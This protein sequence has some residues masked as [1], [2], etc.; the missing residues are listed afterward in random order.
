MDAFGINFPF[1]L[2]V[3]IEHLSDLFLSKTFVKLFAFIRMEEQHKKKAGIN[4]K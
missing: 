4:I 1:T 2:P 3:E